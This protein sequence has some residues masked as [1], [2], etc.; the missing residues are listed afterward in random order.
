MKIGKREQDKNFGKQLDEVV[1]FMRKAEVNVNKS[2]RDYITEA[3]RLAKYLNTN[4]EKCVREANRETLTETEALDIAD[5]IYK[6][7]LET[8]VDKF[9]NLKSDYDFWYD[10]N[11]KF[12][13]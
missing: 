4:L 12:N 2:K 3:L 5:R 1:K 8:N 6:L 7:I 9:E 10:Q 11:D 13:S